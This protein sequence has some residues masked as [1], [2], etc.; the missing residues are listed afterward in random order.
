MRE[1]NTA[2]IWGILV[3]MCIFGTIGIVRKYID[4]S[5]GLLSLS[6]AVIGTLFLLAITCRRPIRFHAIRHQLP[7]LAISGAAIG[8]NWI[9]L[10]EAYRC[11]T[12]TT[13]TLCY[14]TAPSFVVI[15]SHFILKEQLTFKKSIC[16]VVA[17]VGMVLIS[18]I[19]NDHSAG[20][21]EI[22]GVLFGLGAA[23]LYASVIILNRFI[24]VSN[25][26]HRTIFQLGLGATV[27]LP[28]TIL[29]D[30]WSG[31]QF[32]PLPLMLILVLGVVH[33]GF[34]YM[35]Y[36]GAVS[37]LPAQ[38]AAILSYID[39][40]LAIILSALI[41]KEPMGFKEITGTA[42]IIGAA[43]VSELSLPLKMKSHT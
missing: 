41:L 12:V 1:N 29:T 40:L 21:S 3:S 35:L 4:I 17:L 15:A 43:L 39:P 20:S 34:A 14:Y 22:Y 26:A 36:F 13:A 11:T 32:A 23:V 27:L 31:M 2:P 25:P 19:L 33:T 30:N 38:T 16:A 9:F 6:R 37:K 8:F 7:L 28:Y 10:F 24:K 18:G 5:S 42:L